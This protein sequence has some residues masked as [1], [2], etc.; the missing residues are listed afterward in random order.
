[1][2]N[3]NKFLL[4]GHEGFLGSYL[5]NILDCNIL[6]DRIIYNDGIR[7]NYVIN[8]IGKPDIDFCE[9]NP[10]KSK[11]SNCD[12]VKDI[13][14]H[15]P[16][17]ILINFSSYYVYNDSSL[18][19]EESPTCDDLI[20]SKHKLEGEKNNPNGI[21]FRIGKIFGKS[22]KN[23]NKLTEKILSSKEISLDNI[24]FNPVSLKCIANVLK[25]I[26]LLDRL[27]GTY[28]LSNDGIVSH[29]YYAKFIVDYLQLNCK[30]NLIENNQKLFSNHGNFCMS[31]EKIKK[32]HSFNHWSED[33]I[34][35]LDN[36]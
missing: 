17:S 20:Y 16:N 23:Q 21:N 29:F 9:K 10:E 1:M 28:N 31:I 22:N 8:C 12:V 4:I 35:Y 15:Y 36:L 13:L 27:R 25:N 14:N 26:D 2:K 5:L 6:N 33:M 7:Y 3:F 34:D 30:L 19:T 18:C 32:Y 11:Y 24:N